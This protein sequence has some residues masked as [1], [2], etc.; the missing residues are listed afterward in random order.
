MSDFS[1]ADLSSPLSLITPEL[2]QWAIAHCRSRTFGPETTIPTR[3]GLLYFVTQGFV[4]LEGQ[5]RLCQAPLFSQEVRPITL[6]FLGAGQPFDLGQSEGVTLQAIAQVDQ[7]T[8]F[9]LYWQDLALWP[10]LEQHIFQALRQQHQ[11]QL[12]RQTILSQGK[13]LDR[14][15]LYLEMLGCIHG[16]I[17]PGGL[18][19]PF[20]LTSQQLAGVLGVAPLTV[21]RLLKQLLQAGR[22]ELFGADQF[23]ICA[24]SKREKHPSNNP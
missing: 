23:K 22:L 19:L 11:Q 8:V 14:L 6:A 20:P 21:N 3:A 18:L 15:W 13:T 12:W 10:T 4:R 24:I 1:V 2:E 16:E 17:I 9:W 7:T 5:R